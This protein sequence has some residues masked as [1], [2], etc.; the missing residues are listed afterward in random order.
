[1]ALL[2]NKA[3]GKNVLHSRGNSNGCS[4]LN[5]VYNHTNPTQK[6]DLW[7]PNARIFESVGDWTDISLIEVCVLK[8]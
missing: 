5:D 1:M 8:S 2:P 4:V 6:E 7:R 3:M